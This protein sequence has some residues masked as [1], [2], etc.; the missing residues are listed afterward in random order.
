MDGIEM[1]RRLRER[2]NNA[3]VI[4]LTAYDSFEYAQSA[5]RL[6]AVDFC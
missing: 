2:G 5:L 6:G 1:L 3:Y 4:I